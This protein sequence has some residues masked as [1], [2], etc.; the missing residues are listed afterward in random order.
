MQFCVIGLGF[1]GSAVY[2]VLDEK[3]DV[4]IVDPQKFIPH[5]TYT[6]TLSALH[7]RGNH[8]DGFII[9]VPTPQT[10]NGR[11]DD[12]LVSDYVNNIHK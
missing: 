5:P 10:D 6:A 2:S 12:T 4:F 1:V 7:E 3:H 8:I 9:C 11:C